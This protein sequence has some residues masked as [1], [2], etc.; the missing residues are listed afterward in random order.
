M[1]RDRLTD[2]TNLLRTELRSA[3]EKF[4]NVGVAVSFMMLRRLKVEHFKNQ[5]VTVK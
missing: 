2:V 4:L 5:H 1:A 3:S